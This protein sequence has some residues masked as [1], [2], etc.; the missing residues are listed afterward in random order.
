MHKN[1][2]DAA[3][4]QGV[5]HVFYTSLA[6]GG[7]LESS[8][9]AFVM[10][11]HLSTEA[12]L[13]SLAASPS[14][15]L[16]YTA[17]REGLYSESYPLYLGFFDPSHPVDEVALPDDGNRRIA[18]AAR[19]ELGEATAKLIHSYA[20]DS[21]TFPY[22]NETIL[23][24]GPEALPLSGVAEVLGRL[25]RRPPIRIRRTSVDE[26]VTKYATLGAKDRDIAQNIKEWATVYEAIKAGEC[27]VVTPTLKEW[28][29]R[30]PE[31]FEQTIGKMI[32]QQ[33]QKKER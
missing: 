10:Q 20:H 22:I 19:Y 16:T 21:T 32:Q 24:S 9:R 23:L 17:I 7:N 1:A 14:H 4:R 13:A 3:V 2:I 12:Y 6:Y 27:E 11:A 15:P 25:L 26:Y 30:E 29:G 18:W 8:S 28:L 5:R 33:Q 31:T